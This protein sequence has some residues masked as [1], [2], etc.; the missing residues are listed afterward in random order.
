MAAEYGSAAI[1]ALVPEFRARL[2]Q[3]ATLYDSMASLQ[4]RTVT[5]GFV[6]PEYVRRFA[7]GEKL[8]GVIDPKTGY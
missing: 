2:E 4:E 8:L 7:A 3:L 1:A 6:K 5:T